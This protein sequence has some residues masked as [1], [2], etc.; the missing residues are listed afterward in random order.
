[1]IS[2]RDAAQRLDI[3]LDMARRHDFPGWISEEELADLERNPPTWL[4]QSRTNRASGGRPIWVQ[5]TCAVCGRTEAARPKKWWPE[6]T[7]LSCT[8]HDIWQLPEPEAGLARQE[9]D[10]IGGYFVGVVDS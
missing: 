4:A 9:F 10:G 1:M 2:R 3:P 7:Y 6:F 8:E 5:L